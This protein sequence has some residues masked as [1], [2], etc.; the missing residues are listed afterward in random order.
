[1]YVFLNLVT[2]LSLEGLLLFK[3][4]KLGLDFLLD[5][6]FLVSVL[7]VPSWC[8]QFLSPPWS[9]GF[10]EDRLEV[11][12]IE[13]SDHILVEDSLSEVPDQLLISAVVNKRL[14]LRWWVRVN[15]LSLEISKHKLLISV[16]EWN[17]SCCSNKA[18]LLWH[19]WFNSLKV[20]GLVDISI[21]S[22][23]KL[24]RVVLNVLIKSCER[25]VQ[26]VFCLYSGN[27]V[28]HRDSDLLEE[29]HS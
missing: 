22:I 18:S 9:V 11:Y 28:M 27:Q 3:L 4:L 1:M 19:E 25:T 23:E 26:V 21:I 8:N 6:E 13:V 15:R 5:Q 16:L 20:V 24:L 10:S 7:L 14:I 12:I 2:M 29:G 17:H